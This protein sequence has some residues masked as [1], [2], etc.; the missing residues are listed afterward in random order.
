MEEP[1]AMVRMH[2]SVRGASNRPYSIFVER[3][4]EDCKE[5]T[6]HYKMQK[7]LRNTRDSYL[8]GEN[9]L[10]IKSIWSF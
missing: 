6:I 5:Y 9:P 4:G 7:S 8:K 2:G 3:Q 1:C 10:L